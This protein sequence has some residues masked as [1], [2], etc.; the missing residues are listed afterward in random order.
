MT[1]ENKD[2]VED[3]QAEVEAEPKEIEA[4]EL[5]VAMEGYTDQSK[6]KDKS[7]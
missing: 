6:N 2:N 7:Q 3:T 1:N 4:P 5:R